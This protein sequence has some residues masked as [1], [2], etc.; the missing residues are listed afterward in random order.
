MTYTLRSAPASPFARKVRMAALICGLGD[1]IKVENPDP[2]SGQAPVSKFNPLGKIPVLIDETGGTIFDSPVIVE[3]IDSITEP[4]ILIPTEPAARFEA[5][6]LQAL[7]DGILD[8]AILL[9]Y[10]GRYRP[11]QTP[12]E[13]WLDFQRGKIT[14][15]LDFLAANPPAIEPVTVG[16]V[17]IACALGYLD[18]R[19]GVDWRPAY[20]ALV[21]WLDAF[22]KAVPAFDATR[23]PEA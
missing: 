18:Y 14:T 20:P 10:E 21:P 2:N 6:K 5:L 13:P 15:A 1:E 19:K 11:D 22:A 9:V 7:G 3:Y 8:A 4:G 16:T 23:P 17:T 12:Y